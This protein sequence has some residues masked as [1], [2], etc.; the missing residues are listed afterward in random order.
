MFIQGLIWLF[1]DFVQLLDTESEGFIAQKGLLHNKQGG[2]FFS[3]TFLLWG[4]TDFVKGRI[5][6]LF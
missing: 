1:I 6:K 5:Q 4:N 3:S 2:V